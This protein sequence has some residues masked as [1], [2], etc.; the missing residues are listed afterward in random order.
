VRRRLTLTRGRLVGLAAF[1]LL[2]LGCTQDE[3]GLEPAPQAEAAL[4]GV[5]RFRRWSPRLAQGGQP[6]GDRGYAALAA[7]GVSLV[8]SVDGQPPDR[9]AAVRHG[10]VVAHVPVGYDGIDEAES[11]QIVRA[12]REAPAGTVFIHC[13]HGKHRGPAAAALARIGLEGVSP[14]EA[15][16]GL[17]ASECSPR[18]KGLYAVVREFQAPD[19]ASL[20]ACPPAPEAVRPQG[21]RAAM[22]ELSQLWQGLE[23]AREAGWRQPADHPD[24]DPAHQATLVW[25]ALR[26][27]HRASK[28]EAS[29]GAGYLAL[30]SESELRARELRD[31]LEADDRPRATRR[32]KLLAERCDACHAEFRN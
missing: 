2:A 17:E 18:Y 30:A 24:V 23:A 15:L 4:E 7:E 12:C 21:T 13:H 25:E 3:V 14:D 6:E 8:L 29:R 16:A 31:A 27:L 11:L 28:S 9:E 22:V 32:A 1:A 19:A 10:L 5:P 20:A 26:E